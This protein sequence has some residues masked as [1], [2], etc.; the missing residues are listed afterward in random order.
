MFATF[1]NP[2]EFRPFVVDYERDIVSLSTDYAGVP[3][4][5]ANRLAQSKNFEHL[6]E[7]T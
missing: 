4:V 3:T 7:L 1:A 6:F 5:I 2:E